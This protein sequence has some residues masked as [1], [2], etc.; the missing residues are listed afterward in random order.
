MG[1]VVIA[2]F[3]IVLLSLMCETAIP[4]REYVD[5]R[6]KRLKGKTEGPVGK[7]SPEKQAIKPQAK[8]KG[9][10]HSRKLK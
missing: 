5:P 6:Y 7:A 10:R 4:L 3:E 8:G 2:G 1:R 9:S